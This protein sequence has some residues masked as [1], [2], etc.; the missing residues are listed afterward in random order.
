M[1]RVRRSPQITAPWVIGLLVAVAAIGVAM[2]SVSINN[3]MAIGRL[4]SD[5]DSLRR[6]MARHGG[7]WS[8]MGDAVFELRAAMSKVQERIDEIHVELRSM[9]G[10]LDKV[11]I[12]RAKQREEPK[13]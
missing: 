13:P 8:T 9:G 11:I 4:L 7:D 12:E 6:S 5:Q 1:R 10:Q 3:S 2:V